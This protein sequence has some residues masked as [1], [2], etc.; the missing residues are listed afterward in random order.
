MKNKSLHYAFKARS[1]KELQ[2]TK[3]RY[4]SKDKI[5]DLSEEEETFWIGF[6]NSICDL[7]K[8]L[9]ELMLKSESIVEQL[10]K[11]QEDGSTTSEDFNIIMQ[12][13]TK[14]EII[15]LIARALVGTE[16]VNITWNGQ[17]RINEMALGVS[18]CSTNDT[19]Q[20]DMTI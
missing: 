15:H 16:P 17:S 5:G 19:G 8:D 4:M 3:S 14:K 9:H 13:V 12:E 20:N 7:L 18:D 6:N 2:E 10:A 11:T 1:F